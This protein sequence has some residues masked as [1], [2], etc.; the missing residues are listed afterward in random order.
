[1]AKGDRKNK[2][3]KPKAGGKKKEDDETEDVALKGGAVS[4]TGAVTNYAPPN[5]DEQ[6]RNV[7]VQSLDINYFGNNI[8]VDTELTLVQGRRYGLIGANGCGKSTLLNVIGAGEI[9]VPPKVNLFHLRE[10]VGSSDKSVLQ[11]VIEASNEQESLEAE[12]DKLQ[13][14][15]DDHEAQVR[16]DEIYSR[17]EELEAEPAEYRAARILAG[18]GFDQPMQERPTSSYSGGWRMRVALAQALFINPSLLLLDEP[19]NHLDIEA[20]V[21]LEK[22]LA[23]FKG[24]LLMISHSQ[25]FMNAI[26]T[27]VIRMSKSKLNYYT[28]NYDQYVSQRSAN[29]ENQQKKRDSEQAQIAHM[30]DY[31]ARF[32]HGSAKLARQAQSKEKVLEKMLRGGLTDEVERDA[33]V[34]FWFPDGGKLPP[35]VIAFNDVTFQYPIMDKPLYEGV[36]FGIDL[37]SKV[38]LV[39]PNGAGKT[40]LMKLI[41]G[42][43]SETGGYIQRNPHCVIARFA[44][45]AVDQLPLDKT[46]LEY[47]IS[48]YSD[49]K[50]VTEHRSWL[51][52]F[53]I[54]GKAQTQVMEQLS[55][56]QKTRVTLSWMARKAPHIILLDEP[57]NHLDMDSIDALADGLNDFAGGVVLISHDM[58]LIAQVCAEIW[59]SDGG[60][61]TRFKG[62]IADYKKH[63]QKRI[64]DALKQ[65]EKKNGSK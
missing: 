3:K 33:Q 23:A 8:L 19:T 28:G 14:L 56:G 41:T 57:T 37:D 58:R 7:K 50:E 15:G 48:E 29:E 43:L 63:V 54:T 2:E 60:T 45:H 26:C 5:Y 52:R 32:G 1:M 4:K 55:D 22:Y 12:L 65:Y 64:A 30:K 18:L 62:E 13:E 16:M 17:L 11:T 27:N 36:N 9:E 20:I 39:G 59:I 21:W 38:C 10:E 53:G 49:T 61:V 47:H 25:D 34:N 24:I 40:T 35:P 51:G 44:Q 46:P 6:D 31:I 42:E